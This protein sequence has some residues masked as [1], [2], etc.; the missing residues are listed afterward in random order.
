MGHK[1]KVLNYNLWDYDLKEELKDHDIACFTGFEEFKP[2]VLKDEKVCRELGLEIVIGG[3]LATFNGIPEFSGFQF[4]GEIETGDINDFPYP[5]YEGFGIGE[6]HKRHDINY[7][8]ILTSRGCPYSC[9]FCAQTCKFR[10]RNLKSVFNEIDFYINNYD[11]E[12]I[13]FND[14]TLNINKPRWMKICKGMRIP[15]SAAIRCQPFDEEM[16]WAAK[17][18]GCQ[19]LVVG[20][21]SF[22][23]NKLDMMNK[24]IRVKSIYKTLD[25]LHKYDIDYH[26]NLLVGFENETAI[27]ITEEI[28]SSVGGRYNIFPTL[29]QP[30]IGTNDGKNR[31]IST[32][33]V[34][35]FTKIFTEYTE[36]KGKYCYP[37]LEL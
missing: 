2:Y 14:N 19:Y 21:E 30:F 35:A 12:M 32:A 13:V 25:L 11:A 26:G 28:M 5:D 22:N 17:T 16:A 20:V 33:E 23:Q 9:T 1:V 10:M 7:M 6:Y 3:A 31:K 36:A 29:V 27:E 8:G 18:S 15:W 34:D 37:Q 4:K 24:K